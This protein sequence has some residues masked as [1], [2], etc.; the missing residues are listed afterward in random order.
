MN[1]PRLM[2]CTCSAMDTTYPPGE[3][4]ILYNFTNKSKCRPDQSNLAGAAGKK[5]HMPD[6]FYHISLHAVLK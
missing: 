1:N 2:I 3:Y 6:R 4:H 5:E